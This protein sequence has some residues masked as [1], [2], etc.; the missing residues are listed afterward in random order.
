[1]NC[2][3]YTRAAQIAANLVLLYLEGSHP[4]VALFF[5]MNL[6]ACRHFHYRQLAILLQVGWMLFRFPSPAG[7]A[8]GAVTI[9]LF[10]AQR[11]RVPYAHCWWHLSMGLLGYF[12][13]RACTAENEEGEV[14][15]ELSVLPVVWGSMGD[16]DL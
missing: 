3:M 1:M 5:V 6:C 10:A 7:Y 8:S 14:C 12:T 4:M 15:S 2:Y 16:A 11:A 9:C 13:T